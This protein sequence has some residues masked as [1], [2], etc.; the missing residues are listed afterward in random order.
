MVCQAMANGADPNAREKE[1]F[2]GGWVGWLTSGT[3]LGGDG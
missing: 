3:P 2:P 1:V